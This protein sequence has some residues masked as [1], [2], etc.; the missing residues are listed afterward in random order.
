MRFDNTEKIIS[1]YF[2][3]KYIHEMEIST[4]NLQEKLG[5]YNDLYVL[6]EDMYVRDVSEVLRVYFAFGKII[7][8]ENSD[9]EEFK[10]MVKKQEGW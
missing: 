2:D 6:I 9:V 4:N 1:K 7:E 5:N 3:E 8:K 10:L